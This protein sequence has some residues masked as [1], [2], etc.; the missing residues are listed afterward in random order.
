MDAISPK[1]GHLSFGPAESLSLG[2]VFHFE[3]FDSDGNLKWEADAK[4]IVTNYAL[5]SV[6]DVYLR[7]QT[8]IST[9]YM[10]LVDNSG[11]TA[12]AAGDGAS[13]NIST[14]SGWNEIPST[15]G[16]TGSR[17]T[18]TPAAAS[19]QSISNSSTVNFAMLNTYTVKGAFLASATG[20]SGVLFCEAAFTGGNQTVNNGDTLKVTYTINATTS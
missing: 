16:Y 20:S 12:F 8:Q 6:L 11:F 3:C 14:H 9:W 5:N 2:G 17:P 18:W 1:D 13:G 15:T 7:A 10:G 4:N 19:S